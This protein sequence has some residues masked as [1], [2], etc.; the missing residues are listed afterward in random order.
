MMKTRKN[1]SKKHKKTGKTRYKKVHHNHD[2]KFK[3]QCSPNPNNKDYTCYSDEALS[4]MKHYWNARHPHDK[5]VTSHTKEIWKFFKD[6][7]SHICHRES[8]W[9]RS[10]FMVGKL[11]SE[12]LRIITLFNGKFSS[13]IVAIFLCYKILILTLKSSIGIV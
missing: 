1:K 13:L 9:L 2:E 4:K 12:L 6:A 3:P 7:M 11:N 5:I 8:C 10:K